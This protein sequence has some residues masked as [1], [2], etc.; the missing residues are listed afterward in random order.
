MVGLD[1]VLNFENFVK[2]FR[3]KKEE[4][5]VEFKKVIEDGLKKYKIW[6]EK[7]CNVY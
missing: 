5:E 6:I 4:L 1:K 7:V 3:S 2:D